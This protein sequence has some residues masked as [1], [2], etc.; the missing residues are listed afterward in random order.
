[1]QVLKFKNTFLKP[2]ATLKG[3]TLAIGFDRG[4]KTIDL[5]LTDH[6]TIV[7]VATLR[8]TLEQKGIAYG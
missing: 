2:Y 3:V 1:M 5:E 7:L 6:E 8:K 4:N